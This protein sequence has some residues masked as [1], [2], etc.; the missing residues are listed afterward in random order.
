[1]QPT[2]TTTPTADDE[3]E[4]LYQALQPPHPLTYA[5]PLPRSILFDMLDHTAVVVVR[6]LLFSL[7]CGLLAFGAVSAWAGV[8]RSDAPYSAA[9]GAGLI[10][11]TSPAWRRRWN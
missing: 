4:R 11:L 7:G 8:N 5:Q 1:M 6:R 3:S 9:W 10:A 2:T